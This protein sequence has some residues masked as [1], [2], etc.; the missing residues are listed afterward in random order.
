MRIDRIK[1]L[2]DV[3]KTIM[4]GEKIQNNI[5]F[6]CFTTYMMLLILKKKK[7]ITKF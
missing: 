5:N 6:C 7:M 1:A 3:Q 2:P 4:S